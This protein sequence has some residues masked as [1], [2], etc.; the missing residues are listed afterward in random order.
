[1]SMQIQNVHL[2]HLLFLFIAADTLSLGGFYYTMDPLADFPPPMKK[3]NPIMNMIINNSTK[4][5]CYNQTIYNDNRVE[6][7]EFFSLT[8]IVQDGSAIVTQVDPQ[9]SSTL[10]KIVNDDGKIHIHVLLL[11]CSSAGI[12]MSIIIIMCS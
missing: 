6:E 11:Y 12:S 4:T 5:I 2:A 9:L 8:L 10:V 1:M 3:F 7:D